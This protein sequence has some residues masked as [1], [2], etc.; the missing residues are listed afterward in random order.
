MVKENLIHDL[1]SYLWGEK[2]VLHGRNPTRCFKE[3]IESYALKPS[4]KRKCDIPISFNMTVTHSADFIGVKSIPVVIIGTK[5][6]CKIL[7]KKS[8]C[9]LLNI[10]LFIGKR[11][12]TL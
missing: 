10:E 6:T 2:I 9:I 7:Q 12:S 11:G 3:E 4:E 5:R 8:C 1:F